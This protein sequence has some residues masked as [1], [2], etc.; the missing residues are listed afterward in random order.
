MIVDFVFTMIR[1]LV[2]NTTF[3]NEYHISIVLCI[4]VSN[5]GDPQT[6]I[7]KYSSYFRNVLLVLIFE[8]NNIMAKQEPDPTDMSVFFSKTAPNVRVSAG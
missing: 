1:S 6:L 5:M 8:T 3:L 4:S 7:S 2:G